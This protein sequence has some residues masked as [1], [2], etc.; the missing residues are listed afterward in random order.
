MKLYERIVE[1]KVGDTDITGLD[2]AFEIEKDEKPEPNPCHIDIFN[3]CDENRRILSKYDTVPVVLKAGYKGLVGIIF[4][5]DMVRCNH[6]KEDGS[7]KTSLACGDGLK[8][9][10]SKQVAKSYAKGTSMRTVI[11]DLAKHL[12]MSGDN[13]MQ[14]LPEL[15][16][17]LPRGFVVSGNPMTEMTRLLAGQNIQA[18][19]QNGSL[20]IRK[21]GEPL[22]NETISLGPESGLSSSPEITDKFKITLKALIM[23]EFAPGRRLHLNSMSLKGFVTI[24]EVR[25]R[26]ANFGD[27]WEAEM[28]CR[29]E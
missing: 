27:A 16:I 19:F 21:N 29:V 22:V 17:S 26:G 10:Q 5:G 20:Q 1:L 12:D 13:A 7:W 23:P 14:K 25:F 6:I 2:I 15:D 24:E 11:T 3:L 4:K 28:L 9:L 18:S 8:T